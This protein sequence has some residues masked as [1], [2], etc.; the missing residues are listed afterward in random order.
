LNA[1]NLDSPAGGTTGAK[2]DGITQNG[3]T[4]HGLFL[5]AFLVWNSGRTV[6]ATIDLRLHVAG[7]TTEAV[8]PVHRTVIAAVKKKPSDFSRVSFPFAS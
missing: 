1:R 8:G 3:S 4:I 6:D 5:R 7:A 2:E